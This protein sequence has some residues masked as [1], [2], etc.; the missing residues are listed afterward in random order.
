MIVM[1]GAIK[2]RMFITFFQNFHHMLIQVTRGWGQGVVLNGRKFSIDPD[3]PDDNQFNYTWFCRRVEPDEEEWTATYEVD[4]NYDGV[5][6]T[7]PAYNPKLAQRIP[8][9]GEP[10]ILLPG[11]LKS[12]TSISY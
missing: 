9:P 7:F 12:L 6:E 11:V 4:S 10:A 2:L 8:R 3:Y 5:M 1:N